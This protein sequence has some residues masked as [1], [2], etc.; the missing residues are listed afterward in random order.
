MTAGVLDW[1]LEMHTARG[2]T[3]PSVLDGARCLAD[4]IEARSPRGAAILRQE[5]DAAGARSRPIDGARA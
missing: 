5:V 4:A 1:L 3:E 2:V